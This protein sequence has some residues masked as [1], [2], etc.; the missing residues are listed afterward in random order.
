MYIAAV[1]Y[2]LTEVHFYLTVLRVALLLQCFVCRLS[3]CNV[4]YCGL[5]VRPRAKVTIDSL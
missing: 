1:G 3:V 4:K 5:T 2:A